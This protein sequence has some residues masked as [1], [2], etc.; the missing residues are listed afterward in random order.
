MDH[1]KSTLI[2]PQKEGQTTGAFEKT[3]A[4][5]R[6]EAVHVYQLAKQRMM[7]I[8]NWKNLAGIGSADFHLADSSGRLLER[9]PQT[10]DLIRIDLPGPRPV[11]GNG[12]DWVRIE[13]IEDSSDAG[14]DEDFFGFRTR[15][16]QSPFISENTSSHF[17]T[18]EATS[19]FVLHRK[20][21]TV[22]AME[23]GRNEIPNTKAEKLTDK[24]RNTAVALSAMFGLAAPQWK[25]LM[26]GILGE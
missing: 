4:N 20:K 25:K 17:Y 18:T 9:L 8:N 19:S 3:E 10:G 22:I 11:S 26:K 12:Y 5:D 24:V 16:V 15:P 2:S 6:D 13:A 14:K 7:N 21:N 23:E 1:N